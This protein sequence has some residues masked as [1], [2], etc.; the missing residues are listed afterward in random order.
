MHTSGWI[1]RAQTKGTAANRQRPFLFGKESVWKGNQSKWRDRTALMTGEGW[2]GE[3]R[4]R[5]LLKV[6]GGL[7]AGRGNTCKFSFKTT[8]ARKLMLDRTTTLI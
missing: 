3:R 7:G 4:R 5:E 1:F 2:V 8:L 6:R